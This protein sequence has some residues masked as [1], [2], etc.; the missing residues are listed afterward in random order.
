MITE[1]EKQL[2]DSI[3][4]FIL[5]L[6]CQKQTISMEFPFGLDKISDK[7][8]KF[9]PEQRDKDYYYN[10]GKLEGKLRDDEVFYY[11]EY[12]LRQEAF[13]NTAR[14]INPRLEIIFK[15]SA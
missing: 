14:L 2:F 5:K 11:I 4:P 13:A 1:E 9:F 6:D 8:V 10:N 7:F 15:Q 3:I 12:K